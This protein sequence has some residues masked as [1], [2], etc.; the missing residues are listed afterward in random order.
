VFRA[1]PRSEKPVTDD[2]DTAPCEYVRPE[3]DEA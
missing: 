2:S 1:V 3:N